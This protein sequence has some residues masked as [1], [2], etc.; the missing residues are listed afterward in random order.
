[1]VLVG[2]VISGSFSMML[3]LPA[4]LSRGRS[5]G[6]ASGMILSI[7]YVGGLIAPWLAGYLFDISG[8]LDWSL[9]GLF[10][11]GLG[12]ALIGALVPETGR[13]IR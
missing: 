6:S 12:W 10:V 8:T 2:V 1:M 13:K 11:I 4:E 5:V 9:E 7:G 3:A